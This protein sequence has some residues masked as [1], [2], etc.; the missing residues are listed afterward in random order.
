MSPGA[1]GYLLQSKGASD[2]LVQAST[3]IPAGGSKE[4]GAGGPGIVRLR[5]SL[6][7]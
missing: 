3:L 2:D 4:L 5:C 6:Y 1:L 7:K